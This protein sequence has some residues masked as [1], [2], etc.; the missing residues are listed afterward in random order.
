MRNLVEAGKARVPW[1]T[2]RQMAEWIYD[3]AVDGVPGLD[4]AEEL[5]ASYL[6]RYAAPDI[7]IAA[8][9]RDQT[10][11]AGIAGFVTGCG[12]FAAWPIA[13]PA[14]LASA[15]Y[16]QLRLIA[17][18]AHLRGHDIR[19]DKVRRMVLACL[20]GSKAA[21]TLKDAGIRLGTRVTRDAI[22]WAGPAVF[23]KIHHATGWHMAARA[24]SSAVG[25]LGR[26]VPLVGGVVAGGFDAAM[27]QLIGRTANRLFSR[28]TASAGN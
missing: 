26:F 12:G 24:G 21:D 27:T 9:I 1:G 5:A 28:A 6:A 22:G 23:N 15:L 16:I 8:L 13:M 7:A 2:L 20:S 4:G 11:K 18:I 14:N 19:S 3:K 10:G 25:R 17:A